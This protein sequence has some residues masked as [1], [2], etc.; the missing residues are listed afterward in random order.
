MP[1]ALYFYAPPNGKDIYHSD[2]ASAYIVD[3]QADP[4]VAIAKD[5]T[6]HPIIVRTFGRVPWVDR[7]TAAW[8]ASA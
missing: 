3:L 4:A 2:S 8:K 7:A 1:T 5:G 6:R